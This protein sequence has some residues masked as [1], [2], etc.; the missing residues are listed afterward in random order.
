MMDLKSTL[1]KNNSEHKIPDRSPSL[2]MEH[3]KSMDHLRRVNELVLH[4]KNEE[5]EKIETYKANIKTNTKTK[6][7]VKYQDEMVHNRELKLRLKK[8]IEEQFKK[9]PV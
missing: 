8:S 2:M 5:K 3:G 6:S 4:I 1:I 9:K 7:T